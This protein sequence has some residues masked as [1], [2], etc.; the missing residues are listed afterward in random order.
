M[1]RVAM[2]SCGQLS[3]SLENEP[4]GVVACSCLKCQKRTGSVF[5]VS[6]YFDDKQIVEV[7]GERNLLRRNKESGGEMERSFCPECGSTVF[8]KA[9]VT[10][11]YTGVPVGAF[12]D[13]TFPEPTVSCW[14]QSKPSWLT[15]PEYWKSSATDSFPD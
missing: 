4:V 15:L 14:N 3:I 7:V 10:D 13:P 1:K 5:A 2:C 11:G 6:S 12:A 8:W 9:D